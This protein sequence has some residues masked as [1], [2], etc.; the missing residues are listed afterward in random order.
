MPSTVT[1]WLPNFSRSLG[2]T[3]IALSPWRDLCARTSAIVQRVTAA[4]RGRIPK[5]PAARN[6]PAASWLLLLRCGELLAFPGDALLTEL[7]PLSPS[8]LG[9]IGGVAAELIGLCAYARL[10]GGVVRVDTRHR[11]DQVFQT[12]GRVEI[13]LQFVDDGRKNGARFRGVD[14]REIAPLRP[15]V[16]DM[17]SPVGIDQLGRALRNARHRSIDARV[18]R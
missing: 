4:S 8:L 14:V 10:V 16:G 18:E 11:L 15:G 17:D 3:A 7:P 1:F 13:P 12:V 9:R 5:T 2:A 6:D